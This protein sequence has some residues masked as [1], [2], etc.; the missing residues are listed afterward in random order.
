VL[1]VDLNGNEEHGRSRNVD[2]VMND[3]SGKNDCIIM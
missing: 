1:I 3:I 2:A